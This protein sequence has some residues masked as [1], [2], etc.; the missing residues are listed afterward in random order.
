MLVACGDAEVVD[1]A[2]ETATPPPGS[3]KADRGEEDDD[4][5]WFYTVEHGAPLADAAIDQVLAALTVLQEVGTTGGTA[6]Q[7]DLARETVARIL[8]GDVLIL[9][10]ANARGLDLWHMC[11]DFEH[12]DC[13]GESVAPDGD[14]AGSDE[15]RDLIQSDL[16]GY[17]WGNRLY[18]S[19]SATVS[20]NELAATLVHEVNHILN[21]SECSY[22]QD[23]NTHALDDS[24]AYLEE[25]RAFVSEC[26]FLR[27]DDA[28][29][30]S[31]DV[32]AN[33]QLTVLEYGFDPDLTRLL[34]AG[35]DSSLPIAE[36]L[37]EG[38]ATRHGALVPTAPEWPDS[39][40]PCR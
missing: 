24:L 19:F 27:G 2:A 18:F 39:F 9:S 14:W 28:S 7:R 22:Y 31:C 34:G 38:D 13:A 8:A 26:V 5:L 29:A 33:E 32:Y 23:L 37:F 25:Y 1:S 12:A 3:A 4:G 11:K 6:L 20:A 30:A 40:E 21:R 17:M 36:A 15:L 35:A 16:A 10:L